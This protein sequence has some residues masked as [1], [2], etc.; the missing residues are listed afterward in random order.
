MPVISSGKTASQ[1]G[2]QEFSCWGE[3][4]GTLS[5]V[6][7]GVPLR[8]HIGSGK[9][10]CTSRV[11]CKKR[12]DDSFI[13]GRQIKDT[14]Y[15]FYNSVHQAKKRQVVI[16]LYVVLIVRSMRRNMPFFDSS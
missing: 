14:F 8:R 11:Y 13:F 9:T 7:K 16:L 10:L 2:R 1:A 12:C 4:W 6:R 5:G 15:A 3:H